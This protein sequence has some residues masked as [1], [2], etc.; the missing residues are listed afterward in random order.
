MD[1]NMKNE[2]EPRFISGSLKSMCCK[3]STYC[4]HHLDVL[5]YPIPFLYK[6][7]RT[8]ILIKG[9]RI[10]VF[11]QLRFRVTVVQGLYLTLNPKPLN[12]KKGLYLTL[13]A[14]P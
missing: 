6:E 14:K 12:P 4:Q 13:N 11:G 10:S 3:G 9:L 7:L 1:K 2:M 8:T 5:R